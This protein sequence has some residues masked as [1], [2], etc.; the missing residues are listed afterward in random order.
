MFAGVAYYGGRLYHRGRLYY[1]VVACIIVAAAVS[2]NHF[3][4][5]L[6]P[7]DTLHLLSSSSASASFL[8]CVLVFFLPTTFLLSLWSTTS[9]ARSP[10]FFPFY[11]HSQSSPNTCYLVFY[12]CL[13]FFPPPSTPAL[14]TSYYFL[15]PSHLLFFLPSPSSSF[16][17]FPTCVLY[18]RFRSLLSD[19]SSPSALLALPYL[20]FHDSINTVTSLHSFTGSDYRGISYFKLVFQ[21]TVIYNMSAVFFST[22]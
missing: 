14:S 16:P 19:K 11:S 20:I 9:A 15:L 13:L 22:Q 5:D 3:S 2:T 6:L 10:V 4:R 18:S 17:S 1:M 21:Y 7:Y 8:F 12:S